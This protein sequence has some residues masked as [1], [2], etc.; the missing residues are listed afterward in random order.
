MEIMNIEPVEVIE[1]R[2]TEATDSDATE[3]EATFSD[4]IAMIRTKLA[5][6]P[7][8]YDDA[9]EEERRGAYKKMHGFGE[10]LCQQMEQRVKR[11]NEA[12]EV[13]TKINEFKATH[14]ARFSFLLGEG[15]SRLDQNDDDGERSA[16]DN[17]R[18]S[19]SR[20]RRAPTEQRPRAGQVVKAKTAVPPYV[21][22]SGERS[23][24][25][26]KSKYPSSR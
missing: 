8:S 1:E 16:Y 7:Q 21:A 23:S 6:V 12:Q 10:L 24:S 14:H 11:H 25:R 17:A 22:P 3:G 13:L 20:S 4:L 9:S 15:A 19:S 5:K 18:A 26:I 2:D